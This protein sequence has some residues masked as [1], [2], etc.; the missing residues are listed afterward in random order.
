MQYVLERMGFEYMQLHS[1]GYGPSVQIEDA[2]AALKAYWRMAESRFHSNSAAAIEQVLLLKGSQH[3]ERLLLEIANGGMGD[4][5][6]GASSRINFDA[7]DSSSPGGLSVDLVQG[8]SLAD[9]MAEDP[10]IVTQRATLASTQSKLEI[11]LRRMDA[12]PVKL[13]SMSR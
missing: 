8:L 10:A 4:S 7:D 9:L 11:V 13:F 6:L 12:V 1:I 5:A 2:K 3:I